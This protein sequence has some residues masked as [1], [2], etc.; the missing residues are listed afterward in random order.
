MDH[1]GIFDGDFVIVEEYSGIDWP[2]QG[3][4]IVAKYFLL[5]DENASD[6]SA[7]NTMKRMS[8]DCSFI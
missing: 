4:L 1:E 8:S 7:P 2:S 6:N 3:D 5:D